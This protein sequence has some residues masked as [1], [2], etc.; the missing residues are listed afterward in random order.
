MVDDK[1]DDMFKEMGMAPA[2]G[3]KKTITQE[4]KAKVA[5]IE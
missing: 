5:P 3:T 1:A 4:V 2:L